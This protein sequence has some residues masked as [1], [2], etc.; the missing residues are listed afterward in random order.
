MKEMREAERT[1][2][3]GRLWMWEGLARHEEESGL[4]PQ[5]HFRT[6]E[7]LDLARNGGKGKRSYFLIHLACSKPVKF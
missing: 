4:R 5:C 6:F 1:R 2:T 3:G 7:R